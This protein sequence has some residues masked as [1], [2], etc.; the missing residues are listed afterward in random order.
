M[1]ITEYGHD[2]F[3]RFVYLFTLRWTCVMERG[4]WL[5]GSQAPE[6]VNSLREYLKIIDREGRSEKTYSTFFIS[7]L[8]AGWKPKYQYE[9]R[10][11]HGGRIWSR[12]NRDSQGRPRAGGV[13]TKRRH[14]VEY[15]YT[16]RKGRQLELIERWISKDRL[17]RDGKKRETE[18]RKNKEQG[19]RGG[20]RVPDV[21]AA[22][23]EGT[24]RIN[25]LELSTPTSSAM[26][27]E[28]R[29]PPA[30]SSGG[31]RDPLLLE[32]PDPVA[33]DPR[34]SGDFSLMTSIL[35][36]SWGNTNEVKEHRT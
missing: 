17:W 21:L 27:R 16:G 10:W 1:F 13:G 14:S 33:M 15:T 32:G 11:Q 28:G 22:W 4:L 18:K 3:P 25:S 20:G 31:M 26:M 6:K 35:G 2:L 19:R 30:P 29:R 24:V 23:R 34:R 8:K 5:S 36:A 12:N 9:N 7:Y